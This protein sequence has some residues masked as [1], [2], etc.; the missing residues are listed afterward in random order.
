MAHNSGH[1]A[2]WMLFDYFL[3]LLCA[4]ISGRPAK[5]RRQRH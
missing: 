2:G 3:D 5:Q 4:R 1:R